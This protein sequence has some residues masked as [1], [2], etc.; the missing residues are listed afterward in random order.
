MGDNLSNSFILDLATLMKG[1]SHSAQGSWQMKQKPKTRSHTFWTL[2]SAWWTDDIYKRK[3]QDQDFL[4][5]S[6]ALITPVGLP[7]LS[8]F[9]L[10]CPGASVCL[11]R[12]FCVLYGAKVAMINRNIE[13]NLVNYK[14][15][16]DR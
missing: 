15:K 4:F 11:K 13:L 14:L 8:L 5:L 10:F 2:S 3:D 6:F 9:L 16:Y 7:L 1:T 12:K